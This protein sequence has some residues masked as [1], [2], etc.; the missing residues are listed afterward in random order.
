MQTAVHLP[1]QIDIVEFLGR[2]PSHMLAV[3]CFFEPALSGTGPADEAHP[4]VQSTSLPQHL[5]R[6]AELCNLLTMLLTTG[7]ESK[8]R[9][10]ADIDWP[11]AQVRLMHDW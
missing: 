6:C 3:L 2:L 10:V 11:A 5:H 9:A 4:A 7:A 8:R 1:V